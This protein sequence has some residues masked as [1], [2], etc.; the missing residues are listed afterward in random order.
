MEFMTAIETVVKWSNDNSGFITMVIFATT[1][2]LGWLSGIFRFLMHRP[3]LK[4]QLI[5]GPSFCASYDAEEIEPAKGAHR[6]A[7]SLYLKVT[8]IGSAGTGIGDISVG[9]ESRAFKNPFKWYWLRYETICLSDFVVPLGKDFKVVP[10]LKQKNQIIANHPPSYLRPGESTNGIVYFEQEASY[11]MYY[12]KDSN[13][14]VKIK[15][16]VKDSFGHKYYARSAIPKVTLDAAQK[17]CEKY[18]LTIQEG[19]MAKQ[20]TAQSS[21]QGETGQLM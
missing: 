21:C 8:N 11:G 6:T 4:I 5:K 16:L 17:W 2:L 20:D 19:A 10:F 3:K 18:G 12:P 15:I 7:I 14:S 9:Y 13:F 1:L